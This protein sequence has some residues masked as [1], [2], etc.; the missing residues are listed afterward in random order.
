MKR[1]NLKLN[2][3]VSAFTRKIRLRR[4]L[5]Q[6]QMAEF[7]HISVRCYQTF[8]K[9]HCGIGGQTICCLLML[10]SEEERRAF[11]DGLATEVWP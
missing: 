1:T 6:E 7:L 8:E 3:Y 2:V 5:S 4:H 9:G 11:V 10:L